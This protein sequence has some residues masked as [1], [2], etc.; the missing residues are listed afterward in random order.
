MIEAPYLRRPNPREGEFQLSISNELSN[1]I[2]LALIAARHKYRGESKDLK[3]LIF[4]V[5]STLQRLTE[6]SRNRQT[7]PQVRSK[8]NQRE[9]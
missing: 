3:Q 6:E 4:E 5:R 9:N 8:N 7:I 1:E 2:A